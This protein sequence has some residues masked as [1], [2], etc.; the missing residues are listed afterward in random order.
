MSN[1]KI[2][3]VDV[4]QEPYQHAWD[5]PEVLGFD[6]TGIPHYRPLRACTLSFDT[7]MEADFTQWA[8]KDD[9]AQHTIVLPHPDTGQFTLFSDVIIQILRHRRR[10]IN[11]Y[12][13]ELQVS[14]VAGLVP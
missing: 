6:H 5:P 9:A 7:M 4:T 13:I 11:V 12:D 2:D 3:G 14:R 8:E 10:D 1:Y